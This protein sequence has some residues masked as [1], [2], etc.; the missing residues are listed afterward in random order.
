VLKSSRQKNG[1]FY[2]HTY[3]KNMLHAVHFYLCAPVR[4]AHIRS[5]LTDIL[6]NTKVTLYLE[7]TS[8]QKGPLFENVALVVVC[9]T[10]RP[11]V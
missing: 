8:L 3:E 5:S 7:G 4:G 2:S 11:I 1:Y 10:R 9:Q 6:G